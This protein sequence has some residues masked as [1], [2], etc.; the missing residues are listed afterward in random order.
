M[1]ICSGCKENFSL[2][3]FCKKSRNKDGLSHYCKMCRARSAKNYYDNNEE[4]RKKLKERNDDH[5]KR[6]RE[7]ILEFLNSNPCVD[8]GEN[9]PICLDFDHQKDKRGSVSKLM[10]TRVSIESLK[11]EIAKCEVRCANC[12]RIK[13]AKDFSW[14]KG[15]EIKAGIL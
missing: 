14:Y 6:N 10:N 2:D 4:M 5:L 1:K 7:F 3:Y 8:C 13:T 15:L 11:K 12:H 9:R